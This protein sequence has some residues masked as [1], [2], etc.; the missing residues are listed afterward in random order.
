MYFW[1]LD[2]KN[3]LILK[4]FF[5]EIKNDIGIYYQKQNIKKELLMMKINK[6]KSVLEYYY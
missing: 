5:K 2:I 4:R 6:T 3:K 1:I